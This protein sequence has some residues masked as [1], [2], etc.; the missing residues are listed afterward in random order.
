MTAK[1]NSLF[2]VLKHNDFSALLSDDEEAVQPT[3]TSAVQE[4]STTQEVRPVTAESSNFS[5]DD[6]F[7]TFTSVRKVKRH[8]Q[9]KPAGASSRLPLKPKEIV[10]PKP[11]N[12][13]E[14]YD[15]PSTLKT[16]DLRKFLQDFDGHYRLKWVNDTSCFVVFEEDSLGITGL[17]FFQKI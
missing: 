8:S 4:S 1:D 3:S 11:E 15:F 14:L 7:E 12:S 6:G 2:E 13:V 17:I 10:I 5:G 9:S 16:N